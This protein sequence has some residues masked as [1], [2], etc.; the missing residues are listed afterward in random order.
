MLCIFGAPASRRPGVDAAFLAG[1]AGLRS[2]GFHGA[3]G[4]EAFAEM[5]DPHAGM[6]DAP[7]SLERLLALAAKDEAARAGRCSVAASFPQ[8]AGEAP[9]VAPSR[10]KRA[11]KKPAHENAADGGCEFSG[12]RCRSGRPGT[13]E[14]EISTGGATA[15][16][17][18]VLVDS[19]RGR[20]SNWTRVRVNLR[21]VPEECGLLRKRLIP[22]MILRGSGGRGAR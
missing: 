4:S 18:D 16:G 10:A 14:G 8:K 13:V 19:M 20:S 3:D 9:R 1:G 17:D 12:Q 2:G 7:G 22:M 11:A 5:A 15:G 6:D 21:H